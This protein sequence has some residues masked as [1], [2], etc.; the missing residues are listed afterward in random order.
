MN[1]TLN[2][3]DLAAGLRT[4]ELG[5]EK[6]RVNLNQ[7]WMVGV[8]QEGEVID[9]QILRRELEKQ[10][11]LDRKSLTVI[12]EVLRKV[13]MTELLR[14]NTINLLDIVRLAPAPSLTHTVCGDEQTVEKALQQLGADDV[15]M[16]V[17]TTLN[18]GF[19]Q[20]FERLHKV[21]TTNH[22]APS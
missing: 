5:F 12:M 19:R 4:G 22:L 1:K 16:H 21:L 13:V 11:S 15:T 6:R 17:H 18:K 3:K 7:K 10:V 2:L 20:T 14:G 9:T 8:T